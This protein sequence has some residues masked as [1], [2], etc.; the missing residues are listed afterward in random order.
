MDAVGRNP[1]RGHHRRRLCAASKCGRRRLVEQRLHRGDS[2]GNLAR[3]C[4]DRRRA[5]SGQPHGRGA[6]V[7]RVLHA[8]AIRPRRAADA[9]PRTVWSPPRCSHCRCAWNCQPCR[10]LVRAANAKWRDRRW[11]RAGRAPFAV[12][13]TAGANTAG[14]RR[15]QL[16]C[17][18]PVV[19][20]GPKRYRSGRKR[21]QRHPSHRRH[22]QRLKH[23][24]YHHHQ[25]HHHQRN[26]RH[27]D[28]STTTSRCWL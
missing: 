26:K 11:A 6:G 16:D 17:R 7:A 8:G 9:C 21:N 1:D 10:A 19:G 5:S 12:A 28:D 18:C 4:R 22:H 20:C 13:S 2:G 14:T 24:R 3:W 25:R 27:C 15:A 23:H